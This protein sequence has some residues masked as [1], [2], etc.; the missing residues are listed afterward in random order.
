M[1][2]GRAGFVGCLFGADEDD[3]G[4]ICGCVKMFLSGVILLIGDF[5]CIR[6]PGLAAVFDLIRSVNSA[7]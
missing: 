7:E 3:D 4:G 5:I 1:S 2:E 6:M